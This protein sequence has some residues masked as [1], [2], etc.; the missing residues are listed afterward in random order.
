MIRCFVLC[1][2][3]LVIGL[4]QIAHADF[5]WCGFSTVENSGLRAG[6]AY[7]DSI[8]A[9]FI[10]VS[11]PNDA[12][13]LDTLMYEDLQPAVVD[14]VKYWL[15]S[16]SLGQLAFTSDTGIVE[17]PG[18]GFS[19]GNSVLS[20]RADLDGSSYVSVDSL[21]MDY[22]CRYGAAP[23]DVHCGP[24][25]AD[26]SSWRDTTSDLSFLFTEIL[27]KIHQAYISSDDPDLVWPFDHHDQQN[28][29]QE[30]V[31]L[32]IFVFQTKEEF[33]AHGGS[34]G[35]KVSAPGITAA[36]SEF[37]GNVA[38]T[39]RNFQGTFQSH[40]SSGYYNN[41]D[42]VFR[43]EN[44]TM[45]VLHEFSHTLG[46]PDGPPNL[47]N[48]SEFD[49]KR[50]Y[51][52]H[53]NI[54]CQHFMPGQGIPIISL[55]NLAQSGWVEVV[56]FT[57]QNK[58]SKTVYDIRSTD[59]DKPGKIYKYRIPNTFPEQFFLFAYHA[60]KGIDG[61]VWHSPLNPENLPNIRS[62][63]LEVQHCVGENGGYVVDIESAFG[64]YR[65]ITQQVMPQID[66][67]PF[68]PGDIPNWGDLLTNPGELG[69]DNYD[70]W[71]VN[72]S[73][74][75]L[76][77][78]LVGSAYG[79]YP[80]YNG[81]R[82]D[83]FTAN[84]LTSGGDTWTSPEFSYR[85]MPNTHAYSDQHYS[86][87]YTRSNPQSVPTSLMVRILEQ[88]DDPADGHPY[89][90]VDFLSAPFG[91]GYVEALQIKP[92]SCL[93]PTLDYEI[94]WTSEFLDVIDSV[95]ILLS[96]NG[97]LSFSHMLATD[98]V[99]D[100][101]TWNWNWP[102]DAG[103]GTT[104]AMLKI[105]FHNNLSDETSE[106]VSPDVFTILSTE[107][108]GEE[109]LR[110]ENGEAFNVGETVE[111]AWTN[112]YTSI[113]SVAVEYSLDNGN[114]WT[115]A[116]AALTEGN[117]YT[118]S[119]DE[120]IADV[121]LTPAMA[122]GA[123]LLRLLF[124]SSTGVVDNEAEQPIVVYPRFDVC[125]QDVTQSSQ[126]NYGGTAYSA[127]TLDVGHPG[128]G[129]PDLFVSIADG[130]GGKLFENLSPFQG[131]I[132]FRNQSQGWFLGTDALEIQ[133]TG[134]VA[135]DLDNDGDID[136]LIASV[137]E[138]RIFLFDQ[139]NDK[140]RNILT[141]P[142]YF[143]PGDITL[144]ENSAMISLIDWEHDGDLDIFVGR[145][146]GGSTNPSALT[147]ALFRQNG[148][149]SFSSVGP[150]VGLEEYSAATL[151]AVWGDFDQDHLWELVV[152][153]AVLGGSLLVFDEE[154]GGLNPRDV[155]SVYAEEK[156]IYSLQWF[157]HDHSGELDLL[158]GY[159]DFAPMVIAISGGDFDH[160]VTL[161]AWPV[162]TIN[163]CLAVD[164]DLD[165]WDDLVG[166]TMISTQGNS[167]TP[168]QVS[169]F[170]NLAGLSGF[171]IGDF[172][173]LHQGAGLSVHA[174]EAQ[175]LVFDDFNQ[176][177]VPDAFVGVNN[178]SAPLA[179]AMFQALPQD[180]AT[181]FTNNR[182]RVHLD[183]N[184]DNASSIGAVVTVRDLAS[185]Q[186]LGTKVVDGGS[187]RGSQTPNTLTFGLGSHTGLVEV[188]A[189]WPAHATDELAT[190]ATVDP[191][192]LEPYEVFTLVQGA[193]LEILT[194]TIQSE[195]V[196]YPE[197]GDHSWFFTWKTNRLSET[198]LDQ[199]IIYDGPGYTNVAAKL[200]I[201]HPSAVVYPPEY[202]VDKSTGDIS[203]LHKVEWKNVPC[204]V[205]YGFMYEVQSC[206]DQGT[207]ETGTASN[208]YRKYRF[209]P[210][211]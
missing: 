71:W 10:F 88:D 63:G 35:I 110:P 19:D 22:R 181:G 172:A 183:A 16:H 193:D 163:N 119:G 166:T 211:W 46:W 7:G 206:L 57:G 113:D 187:G 142:N 188:E 52:G 87:V 201:N 25:I 209:C 6:Y 4:P 152:G 56:D 13:P 11:F 186:V 34:V 90:R 49:I 192:T 133:T 61:R 167:D 17:V 81:D 83:F 161:P 36:H 199:V 96:T 8:R 153:D 140:F 86:G 59:L 132:R 29:D 73:P 5:D 179:G 190:L 197:P 208:P 64:L 121:L 105:V 20:W 1:L 162:N 39:G 38:T 176:D 145:A 72:D 69:W 137:D 177:G 125:F 164:V 44:C 160:L 130:A 131:D 156:A 97:G 15:E 203:F 210:S 100:S 180:P 202:Q 68:P 70:L 95:D 182:L 154:D 76:R 31:D 106:W 207:P 205:G 114:S 191:A 67:P 184:G 42:T 165:G 74:D 109:F 37:F 138:P 127:V 28:D 40:D 27:F 12:S 84:T 101:L 82:F 174:G 47:A 170:R 54:L 151:S 147:D 175:G 85:T 99:A 196:L 111:V 102:P 89:M 126:V 120:K 115:L 80:S 148:D 32:L 149:G 65:D 117:G 159:Q 24:L 26:L 98:V 92:D 108:I 94:G 128:D 51:Y 50:Y 134:A 18:F 118:A 45:V 14:S 171:A 204:V 173:H 77:Q 9:K 78:Q 157:D 122:S 91:E 144:F 66:L 104:D 53:L 75:T 143:E 23:P 43:V 158:V 124:Y 189:H 150:E 62:T 33:W 198:D 103:I 93:V 195:M 185:G 136:L 141:D 107:T 123:T 200:D 48:I 129:K 139:S 146:V 2:V 41:N 21:P 79:D 116:A 58:E 135:G 178:S 155:N 194:A 112:Y 169:L 60:G 30:R 168:V 55:H 3:L